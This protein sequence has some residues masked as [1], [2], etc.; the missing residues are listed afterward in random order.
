MKIL[1]ASQLFFPVPTI[2]IPVVLFVVGLVAGCAGRLPDLPEELEGHLWIGMEIGEVQSVLKSHNVIFWEPYP[3]T[4]YGANPRPDGSGQ[5][6]LARIRPAG[7]TG[8]WTG[9]ELV[10]QFDKKDRL[11]KA[12]SIEIGGCE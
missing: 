10:F 7:A 11:E 5:E 8:C 9:T 3:S 4:P 2:L 12:I 6:I 1:A